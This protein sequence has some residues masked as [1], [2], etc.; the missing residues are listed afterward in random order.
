MSDTL[1]PKAPPAAED[2]GFDPDALQARYRAERDKRLRA[3][4]NEQYVEVAGE[5]AHYLD[6]PYVEPGF[7]ARAATD[8]VEVVVIGGGFGGLLAGARLREA[9]VDDIR[10]DREGRRLR[11][12]LVLEPLSRARCA[13][14]SRYIYLP[15]LEEIGYMPEREVLARAR[16]SSRTAAAIGEHFD[17]YDD[18]C[19]Q[20]EV[21][22]LRWDDDDARWIVTTNRG[23]AITRPL[24]GHG[25][26][27]AAPARSCPA[28]PASRRSRAT[29]STPAAGT[30]TTPAATPTAASTG[31]AGQAGRHHRHRRHGRAVRPAPRR[32]RP[33]SSTS[34]SARRRRS[35][36]ATTARPIPSGPQPRARL[37][38]AADGQLQHP[39]LRRLPG[40]GPGQRR[41]DRHHRQPA[42]HGCAS[43]SSGRAPP[44]SAGAHDASWPTSRRWSRSA[45]ASTTIVAGPG[46]GRGAEAVLP[47]VLQA[48][49]LPRR[50]PATTFNRPNVHAGRH[51]RPGRRAHHRDAASW[52]TATS[53]SSTA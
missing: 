36:C 29:P 44:T 15:L 46:D 35:T 20:T 17:L 23:D 5:F 3:D 16:R 31:L 6:D 41:L 11:R 22:E 18:A 32:V 45:P 50:V 26:R 34:S 33:S 21:T 8:E 52:S 48:A 12:H 47:P 24:R 10:I 53:T 39:G 51:R 43:R 40:R 1:E 30:T 4:G 25:Q 14:S 19:F 7:D 37:A 42:G 13:T 28:S 9:G 27:A 49:V 38:A 2:L